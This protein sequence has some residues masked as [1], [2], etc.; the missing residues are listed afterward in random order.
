MPADASVQVATTQHEGEHQRSGV[1]A[2]AHA[3]RLRPRQK[4][5][6]MVAVRRVMTERW[7]QDPA[8]LVRGASVRHT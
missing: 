8:L 7:R 5:S 1:L 2:A 6:G 4:R 3:R